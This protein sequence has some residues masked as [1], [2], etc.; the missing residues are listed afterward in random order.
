MALWSSWS[1]LIAYGIKQDDAGRIWHSERLVTSTFII[2][3][4][5]GLVARRVIGG[6]NGHKGRDFRHAAY[7]LLAA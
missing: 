7:K 2:Q 6:N 4:W 3:I 5:E 1:L